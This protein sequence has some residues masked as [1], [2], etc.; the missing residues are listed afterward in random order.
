M[1]V[2]PEFLREYYKVMGRQR[3]PA[4]RLSDL[5]RLLSST[6]DS[7]ARA[8]EPAGGHPSANFD[9]SHP[10]WG[11]PQIQASP[12]SRKMSAADQP[13]ETSG[14]HIL[15]QS[16]GSITGAL[17]RGEISALELVEE[18]LARVCRW[19]VHLNA[20]VTPTPELA[21]ARAQEIDQ[22]LA[23]E[24]W[25][26]PLAGVPVGLKD[27]FDTAGVP[28]EGGSLILKGRVPATDAHTVTLL[29][30]AG[31]V[32]P[33]KTNTH[34]FAFGATTTNPHTGPT[35]NPWALDRVPG[36]SSGGSSAGVAAGLFPAA[37]GTDTGGSIRMPASLSGTVGIK[38]TYGL[39]GRTGILALSWSL[40]HPGPLTWHAID[41]A[42]MLSVLAGHDPGDPA[43]Q[44]RLVPDYVAVA[45]KGQEGLSGVRIGVLEDWMSDRVMPGV[46]DSI[47]ESVRILSD[48]GA[49]V[50][51]VT[52]PPVKDMVLVN[53][54]LALPE[55]AAVH[56]ADLRDRPGDYGDDVRTRLEMGLVI[57][58]RDY[59]QAQRWRGHLCQEVA[60]V[61]TDVDM[62]ALPTTPITA[63][64]IGAAT[65]DWGRDGTETVAEALI[66]LT[67]PFNV[68][69]QPAISL[70]SRQVDGLPVGLQLVGRPFDEPLLLRAAVAYQEA[71][72]WT[73]TRPAEPA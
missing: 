63:P 36:G 58:A 28:T 32:F 17:A 56:S 33:G 3:V 7:T 62:L 48:L 20:M 14:S 67:A 57:P 34:E 65:V 45:M 70:P 16:I 21:R 5:A 42:W 55:A 27:L 46:R 26:G 50:E 37:M 73:G 25:P 31:A 11:S 39:I 54:L 15:D 51:V 30:N 47:L 19:D 69:G 2:T 66:R 35:R 61:M 40:D 44:K 38:P 18:C 59:I 23:R 29:G 43:S 4:E 52:I 72:D 49:Q 64:P 24:H 8:G 71:R 6:L 10:A 9:P 60:A 41:A 1:Q 68:T 13:R 12:P 53:R 22:S